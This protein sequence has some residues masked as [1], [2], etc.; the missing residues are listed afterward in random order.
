MSPK[1]DVDLLFIYKKSNKN[2]RDFITQLNNTLWD[3]GLEVGISF[4]TIKQALID[5]K[6]D[7]K[8]ITKFVETR[9]IIGD[10]IQYGEFVRSIKIL[11]GK[12]NPLK[13][14]ELKLIELV[15]QN[16]KLFHFPT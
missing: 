8:T 9:F 5:S 15:Y 16:S 14:S 4:L 10:E 1:S 3:I 7:I 12:Q 11:I 2:I 6:K 13:L